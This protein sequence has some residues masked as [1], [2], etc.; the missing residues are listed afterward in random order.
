MG[1][2]GIPGLFREHRRPRHEAP[3]PLEHGI[4]VPLTADPGAT[5]SLHP[6]PE[7][8]SEA[9]PSTVGVSILGFGRYAGWSLNQLATQDRSYLEWLL[10]SSGGRQYHAEI[11]TLL[12]SR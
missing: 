5:R 8:W 12:G 7:T 11:E 9:T 2:H 10:R 1:R 4:A 3:S 6:I